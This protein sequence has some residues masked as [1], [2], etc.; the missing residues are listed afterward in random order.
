M[1]IRINNN[2]NKL[3][4]SFKSNEN[5][6]NSGQTSFL[7]NNEPKPADKWVK[8]L[9]YGV[10]ALACLVGG[11]KGI[12]KFVNVSILKK[13]AQNTERIM[14]ERLKKD[15]FMLFPELKIDLEELKRLK[16]KNTA[17]MW[18][19]FKD[20]VFDTSK[21]D[22]DYFKDEFIL[23]ALR[24]A[25][26]LK[27]VRES[28]NPKLQ[29]AFKKKPFCFIDD[30][31]MIYGTDR[32]EKMELF[33]HF[34]NQAK[35]NEFEIIRIDTKDQDVSRINGEIYEVFAAAK[36]RYINKMKHTMVVVE[37]VDEL[38]RNKV[39]FARGSWNSETHQCGMQGVT[40][41][42]TAK[43]LA[44]L[45]DTCTRGGRIKYKINIDD[46]LRNQA[47]TDALNAEK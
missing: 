11:Y 14:Q 3:N 8:I 22:L 24:P 16:E 36:E 15:P 37:N 7:L 4:S 32:P 10:A 40:T 18:K 41:L 26:R 47:E 6:T 28:T 17:K 29:E 20:G 34:L 21:V 39:G 23:R 1:N 46:A 5:T 31:I 30:G 25:R 33:N 42:T 44:V 13:E 2:F 27:V 19:A 38:L 43:D 12:R 45:D 9:G 35:A